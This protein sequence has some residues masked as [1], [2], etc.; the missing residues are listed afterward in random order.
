MKRRF[1][2]MISLLFVAIASFAVNKDDVTMVSYEQAWSDIYGTLALKNNTSEKVHNVKFM[3]TYLDMSGTELDYKEFVKDV[4][5]EPG[6]TKK[7]DIPAYEYSRSYYYYKSEGGYNHTSFKIKYELKDFNVK[8]VEK[9]KKHKSTFKDSDEVETSDAIAMVLMLIVMIM[10]L[11]AVIGLYILVAVL[12][13]KRNRNV[14]V[15]ILLSIISTPLLM[16]LVLL[17]IGKAEDSQNPDYNK[18]Q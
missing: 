17:V 5:I 16:A 6:K 9:K 12:A 2:I 7:L 4:E 10:M 3:I 13:K 14:V 1:L 8:S 18:V 11:G 15:W